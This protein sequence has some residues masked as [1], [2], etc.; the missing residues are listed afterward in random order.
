M[1]KID[2]K[3]YRSNKL[4]QDLLQLLD[5][6]EDEIVKLNK[7]VVEGDNINGYIVDTYNNK[8]RIMPDLIVQFITPEGV[9]VDGGIEYKWNRFEII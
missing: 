1:K 4:K 6:S 2:L 5:K 9:V 8:L 3:E 7:K